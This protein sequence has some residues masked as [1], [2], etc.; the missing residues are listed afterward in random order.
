MWLRLLDLK[1]K[2]MALYKK[3]KEKDLVYNEKEYHELIF[4]RQIKVDNK[5]IDDPKFVLEASKNYL[6]TIGILEVVV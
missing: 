4:T 6:I 2:S 5:F 3:L 1:K